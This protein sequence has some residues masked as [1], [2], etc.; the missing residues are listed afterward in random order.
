MKN[1]KLWFLLSLGCLLSG[2][3]FVLAGTLLGG[4]PGFYLDR[5]G[6]HTSR[7]AANQTMEVF[8][9]TAELDAFDRM[10]LSIRYAE[11]VELIPSDRYAV[12][13]RVSG[14]SEKPVCRVEDGTLVFRETPAGCSESRI[15][16]LYAGSGYTRELQPGPYYVKIEY[17][18]GQTF[19]DV[20]IDM[21]TGNLKLPHLQAD[22]L[23][24]RNEYGDVSVD[25]YTGSAWT[26]HMSS[27]NLT[28]GTVSAEQTR[29]E[30]E[31]GDVDL[32]SYTGN[33]LEVRM[34]SGDLSLGSVK[35]EQTEI[36]NEYG[37]VQIEQASGD[38]LSADLSS[39][40][41]LAGSLDFPLLK[42]NNEYGTVRIRLPEELSAYEYRLMTEYG[43]ILLDGKNV[44]N[45]DE[46]EN[47]NEC[48]YTSAGTNGRTVEISC[49]SG[50]IMIDPVP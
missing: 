23:E 16:F 44:A 39:G 1:K 11:D 12:E 13:Y 41:F 15:W 49:D 9:D 37:G 3:F 35:A 45:H 19:T 43:S 46:D 18:A 10:E 6:I 22:T 21:E 48:H 5:H 31:Y 47:E 28:A 17:P 33:S 32:E 40:S 26:L 36:Q 42:V 4:I 2:T 24:L 25:S 30:S 8:R 34:S 50:E 27:G 29:L 7:D 14:I 38:R 20:I